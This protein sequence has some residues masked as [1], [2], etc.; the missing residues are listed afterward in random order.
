MS[1]QNK[2]KTPLW[3]KIIIGVTTTVLAAII[4]K[5]V[6]RVVPDNTSTQPVNNNYTDKSITINNNIKKQAENN[7]PSTSIPKHIKVNDYSSV[8]LQQASVL[9][10][11]KL[12]NEQNSSTDIAILILNSHNIADNSLA[13]DIAGLYKDKG[14]SVSSSLFTQNFINLNYFDKVENG[15]SQIIQE[16]KL[17][18]GLKY[19]VLGKYENEF[20]D[21]SYT[22]YISR[23]RLNVSIISCATKS[24]S[25]SF[26]LR[27]ANGYDDKDHAEEGAIEKLIEDYKANHLNL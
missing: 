2:P 18:A 21:G 1:N 8:Q 6:N 3:A 16:L 19:I 26:E 13:A 11:T 23:A 12:I 10:D 5:G 4:M 22:K 15:D 9:T 14:F 27:V 7:T 25:N 20:E 17:P 24:Q